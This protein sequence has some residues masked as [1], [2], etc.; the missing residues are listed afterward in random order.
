MNSAKPKILVTGSAGLLGSAVCDLLAQA[1]LPFQTLDLNQNGHSAGLNHFV[2]AAT[3]SQL[4]QAA[5]KDM[6]AVIH[7]AAI[8]N[9]NYGSSI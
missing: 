1:Q 4:V 3:D 2:G 7:L 5:I 8:R 9:P 6:Q